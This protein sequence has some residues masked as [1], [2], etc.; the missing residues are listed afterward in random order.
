LTVQDNPKREVFDHAFYYA[1]PKDWIDDTTLRLR[2]EINFNQLP[3]EP[4]FANNV[5]DTQNFNL[6]ASPTL[7]THLIV[8]GYTVDGTYY[9]PRTNQDVVQ[10]RS[11]IRRAYPL[12]S[13]TGGYDSPDPGVRI[14]TRTISD[15][16]LGGYVE[17]TSE[18][19]LAEPE[20]KREF[21]AAGYANNCAK[22]LHATEGIPDNEL[23]YSMIWHDDSLPFPRGY[24]DGNVSAGP[25]GLPSPQIGG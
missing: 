8:W 7:R 21:C 2:A 11:W 17:R 23:I 16:N 19:C 22:W 24:A 18:L 25:T 15:S 10:A 1:L 4:N 5:Q 3:P 14:K 9:Q 13:N 12:A 6:I 20:E